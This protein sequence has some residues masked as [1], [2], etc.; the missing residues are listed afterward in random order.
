[1]LGVR[2]ATVL[3]RAIF[4]HAGFAQ[5]REPRSVGDLAV[6]LFGRAQLTYDEHLSVPFVLSSDPDRLQL[7]LDLDNA[8]LT[9]AVGRAVA[10]WW[11]FGHPDDLKVVD[12]DW[13]AIPLILPEER[14]AQSLRT[15]GPSVAKLARAFVCPPELVAAHL[16]RLSVRP[17]RGVPRRLSGAA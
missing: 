4:T 3:A 1:M 2:R 6:G 10:S 9:V 14:F 17:A 8:E 13:A 12:I 16:Q 15:L 5:E 11:S 7:S